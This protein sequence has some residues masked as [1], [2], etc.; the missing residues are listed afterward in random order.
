MIP[1]SCPR[2]TVVWYSDTVKLGQDR[3]CDR[4]VLEVRRKG[5]RG[6]FR[7]DAFLIT[8]GILFATHLVFVAFAFTF[9]EAL[10]G[11]LYTYGL[12]LTIGAAVVFAAFW[13]VMVWKGGWLFHPADDADWGILRW[14]LM[15]LAVGGACLA[16]SRSSRITDRQGP[17][18]G[19]QPAQAPF[20]PPTMQASW[21]GT[22]L[23]LAAE[24]PAAT[25]IPGLLG[26]WSF[27]N[28]SR[29]PEVADR[30]GRKNHATAQGAA[31]ANGVRGK[32]LAFDGKGASVD[33]GDSA[34]FNFPTDAPFTLACW[35]QTRQPS[36]VIGA[37]R[38]RKDEGAVLALTVEDGHPCG[39]VRRDRAAKEARVRGQDTVHDGAWH[40]LALGRDFSGAV[41]LFLDGASQGRSTA[42]EAK[43]AITTDLRT[44]GME[45]H[46]ARQHL[47]AFNGVNTYLKGSIDEFCIFGRLLKIEEIR[48]LAGR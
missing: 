25:D 20:L 23:V 12:V 10:G 30:S 35:V 48:K 15:V 13:R 42:P 37:Q 29:L 27:D 45:P 40:H 47:E 7:V 24:P 39:V 4:C 14:P 26:Y 16:A 34:D 44:L 8:T 3:L 41:E 28:A 31:G 22:M 21:G 36:G 19:P 33:Y 9:P 43:G 11:P 17:P 38:S 46:W 6:H 5:G 2:C 32:G 1:V 18:P